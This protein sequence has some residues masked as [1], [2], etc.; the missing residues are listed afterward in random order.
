MSMTLLEIIIELNIRTVGLTKAQAEARLLKMKQEV[1]RQFVMECTLIS[2]YNFIEEWSLKSVWTRVALVL[3]RE[4]AT[5]KIGSC[6]S[7]QI[8]VD[9]GPRLAL[10]QKREPSTLA[11]K[12]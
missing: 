2:G 4:V 9:Y 12:K 11:G 3:E 5:A 10:L 7:R 8:R 1:P 6:G